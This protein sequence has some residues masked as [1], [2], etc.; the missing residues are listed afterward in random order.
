MREALAGFVRHAMLRVSR[1]FTLR[2]P[3]WTGSVDGK[4]TMLTR[5]IAKVRGRNADLHKFVGTDEPACYHSHPATALRVVLWGG[6]V[7]QMSDGTL[8][9]WRPGMFGIVRPHHAH[10]IHSL[11]NGHSSYSLWLRGPRTHDIK[12]IGNGWQAQFE[13]RDRAARQAQSAACS[14]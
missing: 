7:E 13:R 9:T 8:R 3:E 4:I 14:M 5:R 1:F 11:L 6:Y 2:W 12:L 10:R